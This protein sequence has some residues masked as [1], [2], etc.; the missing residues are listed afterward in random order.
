VPKGDREFF[1]ADCED[2]FTKIANLLLE[3][4]ALARLNGVQKGI[5]MFIFR[6]TFG[7]NRSEDA[8]ALAEFAEACGSSRAYISRQLA[9][10]I[11][12]NIICRVEYQPGK[13]PVYSFVTSVADWDQ[14]C[15]DIN[16]LAINA[17]QGIYDCSE[18][19]GQGLHDCT[20]VELQGLHKC[21]IQGLHECTTEGL[22]K[23]ARVNQPSKQEQPELELSVKTERKTV[24]E[25][26][27][28]SPDSL[29][30]Q[31]SE[32]LLKKIL[33]HLPGY[34]KPD[35]QK[36]AWQMDA[37]MRLDR[38]SPEEVSAVIQFA[39]SDSFWRGN[40]LSVDKL[41]KQY[42]QLNSRRLQAR[43]S[44]TA[45][46]RSIANLNGVEADEYKGFFR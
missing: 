45:N 36:W 16:A 30:Y 7:W 15:I 43:A 23:C 4:L 29:P 18:T 17:V 42:D 32:L 19:G 9:E 8:I 2:G 41:R 21:T 1:K 22:Y 40:I 24:K 35:L 37:L 12:K 14:T 6:R 11:K 25:R 39:Q 38:R 10:L 31:L 44:P 27:I 3:A 20:R 28:Y 13:I 33:E 46:K 34:K 5:C 26:E